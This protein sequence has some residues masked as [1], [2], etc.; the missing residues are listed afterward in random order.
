MWLVVERTRE[1]KNFEQDGQRE[2]QFRNTDRK[3][4]GKIVGLDNPQHGLSTAL[5][6][7]NARSQKVEESRQISSICRQFRDVR[8]S[9]RAKSLVMLKVNLQP[10]SED[11]ISMKPT[12]Q[13]LY[14]SRCRGPITPAVQRNILESARRHNALDRIT[15]FLVSRDGYFMQLLEGDMAKVRDCFSRIEADPR[16]EAV[17]VHGK[18]DSTERLMPSWSMAEVKWKD[19]M[20]SSADLV[21]I[22]DLG[23]EGRI[24]NRVDPLLSILKKFSQEA[25]VVT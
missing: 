25:T 11:W 8:P 18:I 22:F 23:R 4:Q 13:L 20:A 19:E 14:T 16:H 9:Y 24:Y 7:R 10:T 5:A 6:L 12:F 3:W 1:N 15:G 21:R 2:F 17:V